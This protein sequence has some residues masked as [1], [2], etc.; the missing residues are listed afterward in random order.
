ME[1]EYKSVPQKKFDLASY[2]TVVGFLCFEVLAFVSFY[3]GQS[4][5]LY[6]IL[7]IVLTI[8]LILI[9]AK[10]IKKE[11]LATY[12][13][14]LFPIFVFGLLTLLSK[15]NDQVNGES[16]LHLELID[17]I[18]VPITLLFM[19]AAGFFTAYLKR[20]SIKTMMMVIYIALGAYVLIN[21]FITMIYYVPFYTLI[22][23]DSKIFYDG[24]PSPV[25]IGKM[26]YM[27]FGFKILEVS[28]EYWLLFPSLLMTA[29]IALFFISPKKETRAFIIYA[30]LS[31]I[32][33]ISL[34]F[35]ISKFSLLTGFILA[36]GIAIIVVAGKMQKSHQ[37][38]NGIFI[39]VGSLALISLIVIFL[40]SQTSWSFVS[41]LRSLISGNSLLNRLFIGNR[42]ASGMTSILENLFTGDK[43]FGFPVELFVYGT[44]YHLSNIWFIDVFAYS[45]LFGA[46]FL[47][48]ALVIGIRRLFKYF[49]ISKDEH[50]AKLLILGYVLGYFVMS[51]LLLDVTPM[52]Y[53]D[54]TIFPFFIFAPF[55]V[56]LY[57]MS[58][59]FNKSLLEKEPKIVEQKETVEKDKIEIKE[60]DSDEIISL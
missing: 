38:L 22:Y 53:Y 23:S 26:G 15:F 42:Y 55:L 27:L 37:L 14:F 57:L 58:Y 17:L 30:I 41:P 40:I 45:G 12:S 6:G 54:A 21:L 39:G 10:Q 52:I 46:L 8:L 34:L 11:G 9:V 20:F 48:F 5:M 32:A 28:I 18:F 50:Y 7:S 51:T 47:F 59:C 1:E 44:T 19:S 56:C 16:G 43:I 24:S 25:P 29:V 31:F 60:S 3:L 35:T 36:C 2:G 49:V 4:F 33:F 13:F